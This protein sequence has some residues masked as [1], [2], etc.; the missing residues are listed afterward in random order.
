MFQKRY[1]RNTQ[2]LFKMGR[3][4]SYQNSLAVFEKTRNE[5]KSNQKMAKEILDLKRH[6]IDTIAQVEKQKI[7]TIAKVEKQKIEAGIEKQR[8]QRESMLRFT[9]KHI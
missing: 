4:D 8:I 3:Q 5:R 2:P 6:E 7:D 1:F 9:F